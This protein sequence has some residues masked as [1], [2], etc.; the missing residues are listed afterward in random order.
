MLW[1]FLLFASLFVTLSTQLSVPS[2]ACKLQVGSP[3]W[4][5]LQTWQNFNSTLSG[6]LLHPSPPASVCFA[7]SSSTID[8]AEC[9]Q[10]TDSWFQSEFHSNDPVSVAYPNWQEDACL[11][12]SLSEGS[13]SCDERPFP[14]YVVNASAVAHVVEAVKFA[15]KAN[16][17]LI[18]KGSGHDLLG[19]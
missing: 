19:R 3:E 13:N 12:P 5:S 9:K 2:D 6:A 17:R 10:V 18:V 1:S 8:G 4:P 7:N 15:S 14:S 11:P 16:V